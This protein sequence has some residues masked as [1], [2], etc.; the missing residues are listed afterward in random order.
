M[1]SWTEHL[2]FNTDKPVEFINI[3]GKVE[4]AVRKSGV[5]GGRSWAGRPSSP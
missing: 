5:K 1:K 3:T 2:S 4:E